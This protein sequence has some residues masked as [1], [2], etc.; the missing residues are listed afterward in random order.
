MLFF[1]PNCFWFACYVS[2]VAPV[3][4]PTTSIYVINRP[5]TTALTTPAAI[6]V[7]FQ[8]KRTQIS[9]SS[10]VV[11]ESTKLTEVRMR[12]V[13][14]CVHEKHQTYC[15]KSFHIADGCSCLWFVNWSF[16]YFTLF[17][18]FITNVLVLFRLRAPKKR[19][20]EVKCLLFRKLVAI[21]NGL[22]RKIII[23]CL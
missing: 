2:I 5:R 19:H 9:S 16:V 13:T 14:W 8:T 11:D 3:T 7:V 21:Q 1:I 23:W 15:K 12:H 17:F 6:V 18:S 20:T 10:N 22:L 4:C